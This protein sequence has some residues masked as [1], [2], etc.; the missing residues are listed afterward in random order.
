MSQTHLNTR[1]I[2]LLDL[3]KGNSGLFFNA[4]VIRVVY[5]DFLEAKHPDVVSS[6]V[7]ATSL[8]S[9][10]A[11]ADGLSKT[12][13]D[14]LLASQRIWSDNQASHKQL[15]DAIEYG[16]NLTP[17][18]A[19]QLEHEISDSVGT[20]KEA[21]QTLHTLLYYSLLIAGSD[22]LS[23]VEKD[24]FISVAKNMN[25]KNDV[26][27]SIFK[28]YQDGIKYNNSMIKILGQTPDLNREMYNNV[29]S[30]L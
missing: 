16:L 26:I 4:Y 25:V 27:Q 1:L 2:E 5:K 30:K 6:V 28:L 8:L 14:L 15:N 13:R 22:G 7:K 24:R 9:Y 11:G 21:R 10:I 3:W 17:T 19:V 20:D 23:N 12:E 29:N 18:E